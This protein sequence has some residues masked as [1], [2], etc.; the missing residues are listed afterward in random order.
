[1]NAIPLQDAAHIWNR[2]TR[3]ERYAVQAAIAR[4]CGGMAWADMNPEEQAAFAQAAYDKTRNTWD[5]A[6]TAVR[7]DLIRAAYGI[8]DGYQ[9]HTIEHFDEFMPGMQGTLSKVVCAPSY[10]VAGGVQ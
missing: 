7:L 2:A 6:T 4:G 8:T 1:M 5:T 9:F 10:Y 3:S